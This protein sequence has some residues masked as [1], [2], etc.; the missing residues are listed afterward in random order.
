M[1][2]R[3]NNTAFSATP[4]C[5]PGVLCVRH[6]HSSA[7]LV[8]EHLHV[9]STAEGPVL[10]VSDSWREFGATPRPEASYPSQTWH[11]DSRSR[12]LGSRHVTFPHPS[13]LRFGLTWPRAQPRGV[14]SRR[15]A[16][17]GIRRGRSPC[18]RGARTPLSSR[19]GFPSTSE[20]GRRPGHGVGAADAAPSI[21]Q[22]R[23]A[24]G[25]AASS[26]AEFLLKFGYDLLF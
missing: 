21:P 22:P 15:C 25:A 17:R 11:G 10:I 4:S 18:A 24:F 16:A 2:S 5:V 1:A 8:P 26:A 12:E 6:Y 14:F 7:L 9:H 19:D 3:A 20:R 23:A 13:H